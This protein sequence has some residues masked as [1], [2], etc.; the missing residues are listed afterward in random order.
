[1]LALTKG[2]H[3]YSISSCAACGHAPGKL[4]IDTLQDHAH[5]AVYAVSGFNANI[6]ALHQYEKLCR[7]V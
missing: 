2:Q 3:V 6:I 4:A 5:S 7:W 1:M